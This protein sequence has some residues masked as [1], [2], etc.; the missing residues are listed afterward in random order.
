VTLAGAARVAVAKGA[1]A[2][3]LA[4]VPFAPAMASPQGPSTSASLRERAAAI[5]AR[6]GADTAALERLGSRY[7]AEQAIE[8]TA[9]ALAARVE[10]AIA[11]DSA[12]IDQKDLF[13]RRLAVAAYVGATSD[14]SLGLALAL[15]GRP[16]ELL[17]GRTYL[18]VA[19]QR[20]Q[21]AATALADERQRR[22]ADLAVWRRQAALA[23]QALKA[24]ARAH[25]AALGAYLDERRRLA[26]VHGALLRLVAEQQARAVAR[27]RLA[28]IAA[29]RRAAQAAT[30][31]ATATRSPTTTLVANQAGAT[32]PGTSSQPTTT[33]SSPLGPPTMTTQA[34]PTSGPPDASSGVVAGPTGS[35][36]ADL[37]AIRN[38]ESGDN[39]R[40]NTGNGYYGAY[41]FS[42]PTWQSLGETGLPSDAPPA[43]QDAAAYRLYQLAGWGSWP[44][45]AALL[46]L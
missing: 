14:T 20:L 32:S 1:V 39:Y 33:T 6:I 13:L 29:E 45:C 27:R 36:A 41:Q 46:G 8:A 38:C 23:A 21:Q 7:V 25:Q 17:A 12:R 5:A 9:H 30:R 10:R 15:A 28:L 19:A 4:L 2:A 16:D 34:L 26:S 44:A 43:V 40:A 18:E 3:S 24:I 22:R 42:L 11:Y 35:I 31:S 37:A